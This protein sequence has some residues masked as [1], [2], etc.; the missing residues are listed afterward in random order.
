M[1][2][3][4]A[5][6][7]WTH[8]QFKESHLS[9]W[10]HISHSSLSWIYFDT[11]VF[12]YYARVHCKRVWQRLPKELSWVIAYH[13]ENEMMHWITGMMFAFMSTSWHLC[14]TRVVLS[15][16]QLHTL[17]SILCSIMQAINEYHYRNFTDENVARK[18]S[19]SLHIR[20]NM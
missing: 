16:W 6:W 15:D 17:R 11:V 4:R 7:P 10:R 12:W 3:I 2:W 20:S 18:P 13:C 5:A 8:Q 1:Q 14:N 19:V 9:L